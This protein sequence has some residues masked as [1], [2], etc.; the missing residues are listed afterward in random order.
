[1]TTTNN[2][3]SANG[4]IGYPT[5][6]DGYHMTW[7]DIKSMMPD[8]AK[9][10]N[11]YWK[12]TGKYPHRNSIPVFDVQAKEIYAGINLN[13]NINNPDILVTTINMATKRSLDKK[14]P[15]KC[16]YKLPVTGHMFMA[17]EEVPIEILKDAVEQKR[18]EIF[19]VKE[20]EDRKAKEIARSYINALTELNH[21]ID[22]AKKLL[23]ELNK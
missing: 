23:E 7:I 1:M 4:Y 8:K 22:D 13:I 21:A 16:K 20:R 9:V 17:C 10:L 18:T 12:L 2:I 5:S 19:R 14:L 6:V 11:E 3:Y 15:W